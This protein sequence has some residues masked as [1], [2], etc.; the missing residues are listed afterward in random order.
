MDKTDMKQIKEPLI[1][2]VKKENTSK[3]DQIIV[4]VVALILA[5]L[6]GA[7]LMLI[8]GKNPIDIYIS[9]MVM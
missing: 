7:I 8:I 4:R 5:L 6:T 3:K 1:R 2:I 9:M